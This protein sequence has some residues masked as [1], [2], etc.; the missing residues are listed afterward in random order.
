MDDEVTVNVLGL[1]NVEEQLT[2]IANALE[3]YI[4]QNRKEGK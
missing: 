3:A 1:G 2:R 4:E